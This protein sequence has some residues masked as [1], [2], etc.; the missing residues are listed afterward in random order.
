MV[1]ESERINLLA[2]EVRYAAQLYDLMCQSFEKLHQWMPWARE[3]PTLDSLTAH[4]LQAEQDFKN[5][6]ALNYLIQERNTQMIIGVCGFPRIHW[7]VPRFEIGY[8]LGSAFEGQG[9]MTESVMCLTRYAV[10]TLGARRLEIHCDSQNI[11][12]TK[13]AER[14]CFKFEAKLENHRVNLAGQPSHTSIYK[15][16]P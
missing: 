5:K 2:V 7:D 10:E 16:I 6:I 14:A 13:V 3:K 15:Y 1:L 4:L 9:Y 8:W 11:A 12:S